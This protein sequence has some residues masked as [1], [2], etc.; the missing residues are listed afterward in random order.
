MAEA[1][2]KAYQT[3][4]D[5]IA[6]GR[7]PQG[8]HITAQDLAADS[9]L[10]RTPVREAMRRLHAEGLLTILPNRGAFVSRW[11][12]DDIRQYFELAALL[13]G[14][15]AE[16][17]AQRI[18]AGE[19]QILKNIVGRLERLVEQDSPPLDEIRTLNDEFSRTLATAGGNRRLAQFLSSMVE[20]ALVF[21]TLQKYSPDEL[22]RTIHRRAEI[23]EA[24]EAGDP[25]W[26]RSLVQAHINSAR[27]AFLR[28]AS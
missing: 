28:P 25:L 7:Y 8:A 14:H 24:L 26:A 3:I 17:A 23:I 20:A 19:I 1:V 15:A 2:D 18:T 6:S 12:E 13:E 9:G 5:G 4:R 16:L 22:R 11:D 10:S 21:S 27:H